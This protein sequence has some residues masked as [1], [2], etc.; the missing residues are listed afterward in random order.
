MAKQT[1]QIDIIPINEKDIAAIIV[2]GNA[3]KLV[4]E[5]ERFGRE[6]ADGRLSKS[7]I[8]NAFGTVR[9]IDAAWKKNLSEEE[10]RDLLREI[11]LLKP[12]LAYQAKR[13]R[14]GTVE[15]LAKVLSVAID[16]VTKTDDFVT[17]T[18]RFGAF[19]DLFE[20]ILAYHTAFEKQEAN[21]D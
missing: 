21:R 12:R 1:S 9:Q 6:L 14:S 5:A 3:H 2:D 17:Q 10:Q 16:N 18:K 11:L 8:R 15:P 4:Q 19:V 20:A 13:D 7:Q